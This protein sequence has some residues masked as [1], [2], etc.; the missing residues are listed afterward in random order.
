MDRRMACC[1][2][3]CCSKALWAEDRTVRKNCLEEQMNT[4]RTLHQQLG[5]VLPRVSL[6][7]SSSVAM[8]KA[9]TQTPGLTHPHMNRG[10]F[11]DVHL[12]LYWELVMWSSHVTVSEAET[13][14]PHG[15]KPTVS[16][17]LQPNCGLGGWSVRGCVNIWGQRNRKRQLDVNWQDKQTV[18]K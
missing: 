16:V 8:W 11:Q 3:C 5:C 13:G 18:H 14:M 12:M 10:G 17:D 1:F 4:R 2:K 9:D 7:S 6:W 15:V